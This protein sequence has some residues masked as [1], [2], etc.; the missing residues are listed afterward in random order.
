MSADLLQTK[1][2]SEVI[3]HRTPIIDVRAPI[4][5]NEGA[6]PESVNLPIMMNEERAQVGTCYKKLG[7]E[8]AI[9]LGENLV[10]GELKTNRV[11]SWKNYLNKNPEAI[12]TCFRGGLRSKITQDW[13]RES[14]IATF[15]IEGGYKAFRNYLIEETLRLS[16]FLPVIVVTGATGVGKT[17]LL[18]EVKS[19]KPVLDLEALAGHRGSAFGGTGRPQ[20]GQIDFENKVAAELIRL[21]RVMA[22]CKTSLILEDESR[23]IGARAVPAS[24]FQKIRSSGVVLISEEL[25]VRVENTFAEYVHLAQEKE[26]M[27]EDFQLAVQ[28]ISKR[29]GGLRAQEILKDIKDCKDEFKDSKSLDRNKIWIEKILHWYYD[30]MYLGSLKKR[31]PQ[32]LFQGTRDQVR[33]FLLNE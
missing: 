30:P 4:E 14:G 32:I 23:L 21:E 29:L 7:R 9:Q 13:L 15:R 19:A 27:F 3:I 12:I 16:D 20:P 33:L 22:G 18:Q 28:K 6:L 24:V 1:K 31:D 10:S 2:F 5:F 26:S 8:A 11:Q 25:S 17:I